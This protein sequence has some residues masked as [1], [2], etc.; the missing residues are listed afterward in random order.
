MV[1]LKYGNMRRVSFDF[2][3]T[4]DM[5]V[6]QDYAFELIERGYEIWICTARFDNA[7]AFKR[8]G[9]KDWNADLFAVAKSLKIPDERIIFCNMALKSDVIDEDNE[10]LWHLDDCTVEVNNLNLDGHIP[11]ILRA[12]DSYW[13]TQCNA[14]LNKESTLL[15]LDDCRDP[16]DLSKNWLSNYAPRWINNLDDVVWVKSYKEF[17]NWILNNGLPNQIAFD[18]DLA[19]RYYDNQTQQE[20]VIWHEKTG[21]TCAK[22][23]VEYCIDYKKDL[24]LWVCQSSNPAGAENINGLLTSYLKNE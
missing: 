6:V 8:W 21:L 3:S 2:D 16:F 19:D 15:W 11:A 22:W 9:N 5:R 23:L 18:H 24:P 13:K 14:I 20:N 10:F 7:E 17:T 12:K 4:L 1:A